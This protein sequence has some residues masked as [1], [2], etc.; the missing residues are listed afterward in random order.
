MIKM[1]VVAYYVFFMFTRLITESV[2]NC[3]E[4]VLIELSDFI[5]FHIQLKQSLK[6][7][8]IKINI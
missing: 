6:H 2:Q 1:R 5:F 8:K 7:T 3:F 4:Q